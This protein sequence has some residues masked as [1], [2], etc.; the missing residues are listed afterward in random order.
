VNLNQFEL[1]VLVSSVIAACLACYQAGRTT[2]RR[3]E[4]PRIVVQQLQ[5]RIEVLRGELDTER[6]RVIMCG[7]ATTRPGM[8]KRLTDAHP[9]WS[10]E[11]ADICK[12][13]DNQRR[14]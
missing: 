14:A 7:L 10:P 11:Y 8:L 5:K 13:V 4:A 6:M 2:R 9:H 1:G 12:F 3:T